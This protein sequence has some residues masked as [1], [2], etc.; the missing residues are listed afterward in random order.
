L[1]NKF[2][3]PDRNADSKTTGL[4]MLLMALF[5]SKERKLKGGKQLLEAFGLGL[6]IISV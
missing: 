3:L 2:V 4:D 5:T 6:K 1:I